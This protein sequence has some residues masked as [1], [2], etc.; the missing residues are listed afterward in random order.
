MRS[1]AQGSRR[2]TKRSR[3]AP[4]R[5][6]SRSRSRPAKRSPRTPHPQKTPTPSR[7]RSTRCGSRPTSWA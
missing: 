7:R 3:C 6:R 4:R 1:T 2:L 5:S